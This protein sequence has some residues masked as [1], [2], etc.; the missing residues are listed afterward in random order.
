MVLE[1]EDIA[2]AL[3]VVQLSNR[4]S[5]PGSPQV[6]ACTVLTLPLACAGVARSALQT[7]GIREDVEPCSDPDALAQVGSA[8]IPDDARIHDPKEIR[9]P[10]L[11]ACRTVWTSSVTSSFSVQRMNATETIFSMA[12]AS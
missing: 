12:S 7:M 1:G 5:L 3:V 6:E 9:G 8:P 10:V 2:Q 11:I 4:T